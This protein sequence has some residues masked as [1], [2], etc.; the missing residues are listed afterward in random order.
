MSELRTR[1]E[2]RDRV[3]KT[4]LA[5]LDRVIPPEESGELKGSTFLDWENQAERLKREV[6]P[7]LLEERAALDGSA[8]VQQGGI[9]PRCASDRVYLEKEMSQPEVLSPDGPVV[10]SKQHCRCRVCGGS[11]SPSGS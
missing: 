11:F 10:I 8:Q 7:V 6:I 9:C 3:I 1:K 4:M 2:A 5:A